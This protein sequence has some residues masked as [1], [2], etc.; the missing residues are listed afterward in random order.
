M[1]VLM[2]CL[3]NICRSPMAHGILRARIQNGDWEVSVDSA[4]TGDWHIGEAPDERA[5]AVALKN[6]IDISDLRA[7]QLQP[8][9]FNA[10]DWIIVM[11]DK[12][13]ADAKRLAPTSPRAKLVR[14][15]DYHPDSHINR[16]PDPYLEGGFD[17]VFQLI[18]TAVDQWIET[19]R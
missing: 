7:R 9:D 14:L 5:A 16:V 6:G 12:N 2:V 13:Y 19:E 3:G 4:G 10:Y 15:T 18:E 17:E 11:D 1:K 8:D